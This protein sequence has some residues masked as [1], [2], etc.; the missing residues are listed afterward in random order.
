MDT[1]VF[2]GTGFFVQ[3]LNI[4]VL[5]ALIGA[6]VLLV[7]ALLK[8]LRRKEI[9]SQR[10]CIQKSLGENIREK[11]VQLK[12]T[13]E[14]VAERIGVSRQAVSKWESGKSDPSTANLI[15]LAGLFEIE[16]EELIKGKAEGSGK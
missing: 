14:F 1:F 3:L 15:A 4:I 5:A 10:M 7:L 2:S 13:Q 11:R 12:M 6:F 16:A 9:N 8:Y